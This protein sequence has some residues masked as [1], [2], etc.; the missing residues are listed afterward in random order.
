M[1]VNMKENL[2]NYWLKQSK[3]RQRLQDPLN[4]M[5][6]YY[7]IKKRLSNGKFEEKERLAYWIKNYDNSFGQ[8]LYFGCGEP[9]VLDSCQKDNFIVKKIEIF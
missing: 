2:L 3:K 8:W 5:T 9:F 6:G 4:R 1:G 7:L